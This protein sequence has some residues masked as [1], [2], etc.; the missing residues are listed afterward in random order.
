[1]ALIVKDGLCRFQFRYDKAAI[2]AI[3]ACIPGRKYDA[4]AKEWTAPLEAL[5]DCVALYGHFGR[6][7]G[8]AR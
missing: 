5:P 2:E 7:V 1:M 8:V 3:K 4:A 6:Q